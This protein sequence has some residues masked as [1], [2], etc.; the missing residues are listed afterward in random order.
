[1][2][3]FKV[4]NE[5]LKDGKFDSSQIPSGTHTVDFTKCTGL[6]S[7]AGTFNCD[8]LFTDHPGLTSVAGATFNN[9]TDFSGCTGLTSLTGATFNNYTDFTGC[10]GLTSESVATARFN[11]YTDFTGCDFTPTHGLIPNLK[12]LEASGKVVRWPA[13]LRSEGGAGI[14]NADY[15]V[16]KLQMEKGSEHGGPSIP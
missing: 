14:S 8:A 16:K 7:V 4:M 10:I 5:M 6:I 9:Y 15:F 1:M 3:E 12:A 11:D 13:P 2:T